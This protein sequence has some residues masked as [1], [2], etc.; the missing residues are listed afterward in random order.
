MTEKQ[1]PLGYILSAPK[2]SLKDMFSEGRVVDKA[3]T[4]VKS[5]VQGYIDSF[6]DPKGV[7]R[8]FLASASSPVGLQFV[9]DLTYDDQMKANPNMRKTY[10]ARFFAENVGRLPSILLIDTGIEF[11]DMGI[12]ELVSARVTPDGFWEASLL[13]YM[14]VSISVTVATLSEEDTGTLATLVS[15]MFS[16]LSTVVNNCIIHN[17]GSMWEVRLPLT[18]ITLGQASNITLEGDSKTTV[19]TRSLELSC[20]FE[21]QIGLKQPVSMFTQPFTPTIGK[22]GKQIP[23]FLNLVPNQ[24]IPLGT[25]YPLYL[26]GM[27]D[28]Y[29]LGVEDPSIALVTSEAPYVLQPRAQGRTR[30]LVLDHGATFDGGQARDKSYNYITDVPFVIVR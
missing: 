5:A 7:N 19:W 20:E 18:G 6:L 25:S 13:S 1:P 16:P 9:T 17:Y 21:S 14:K 27:L 28:V 30:L 11:V 23:K 3:V 4:I 26:E 15:M 29:K 24:E 2:G 22:N 10:L 8:K 12:N